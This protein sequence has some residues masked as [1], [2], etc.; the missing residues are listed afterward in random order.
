M[1]LRIA[2]IWVTRPSNFICFGPPAIGVGA[3]VCANEMYQQRCEYSVIV[4]EVSLSL[5]ISVLSSSLHT[6]HCVLPYN[7]C[8]CP[9]VLMALRPV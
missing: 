7:L 4:G 6:T 9:G 5:A 2:I 8:S 3:G 1:Y